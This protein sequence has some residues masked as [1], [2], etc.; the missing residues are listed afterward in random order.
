MSIGVRWTTDE[1]YDQYRQQLLDEKKA[2]TKAKRK[3][4]QKDFL[5]GPEVKALLEFCEK[6]RMWGEILEFMNTVKFISDSHLRA[7]IVQ[8]LIEEG[9]LYKE[10]LP[11][12]QRKHKYYMV[13]K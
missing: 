9:K 5:K 6:P 1:R 4:K 10:F 12:R 13:K 3:Q 7:S 8:P 11:S 2:R